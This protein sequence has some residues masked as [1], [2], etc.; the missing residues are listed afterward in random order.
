MNKQLQRSLAEKDASLVRF[1]QAEKANAELREFAND[2]SQ[3]AEKLS[4]Q[5]DEAKRSIMELRK[6]NESLKAA[7]EECMSSVACRCWFA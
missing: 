5:L 2:Q 1:Q 4:T 3:Q 6:Y 7:V